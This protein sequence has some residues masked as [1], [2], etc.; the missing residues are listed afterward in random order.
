[1]ITL[2]TKK[3][4]QV[5]NLSFLPHKTNNIKTEEQQQQQ[6][7]QINKYETLFESLVLSRNP[8]GPGWWASRKEDNG[9]CLVGEEVIYHSKSSHFDS[10]R[11][12]DDWLYD[13]PQ[14]DSIQYGIT[15]GKGP[16]TFLVLSLLEQL[17]VSP[18]PQTVCIVPYYEEWLRIGMQARKQLD[19][20]SDSPHPTRLADRF[21]WMWHMREFMENHI[22]NRTFCVQFFRSVER[23]VWCWWWCCLLACCYCCCNCLWWVRA[24]RAQ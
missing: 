23:V 20:M 12:Q 13:V 18:S 8:C 22:Q 17:S 24:R 15:R 10:F 7:H 21:S 11:H 9:V 6:Q 5:I 3:Q 1:M 16:S 14:E 2:V 4:R 19:W